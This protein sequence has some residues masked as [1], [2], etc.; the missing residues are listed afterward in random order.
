MSEVLAAS[1]AFKMRD[2]ASYDAVTM[3]FD[4]FSER[5]SIPLATRVVALAGVASGQQVLDVGTGTGIVAIRAAHQVGPTGRV[6]GIDLSEGMLS[7]AA[8][9]A[10]WA[11]L[12]HQLDFRL[13]DAEALDFDDQ[14]FDAVVSLFA[15]LH[16]P[17][18]LVALGEM[19]RVLRPGGRLVVAVG[20][21]PPWLSLT[22]LRHRAHRAPDLLRTLQG[23][24][25]T[26]PHFLNQLVRQALPDGHEPEEAS[27]ARQGLD[28]TRSVLHLVRQAGFTQAQSYWEGH[29]A[30]IETPEEFWDIQRTFSSIARK[31]LS[32][33]PPG[34]LEAIRDEFLATCRQVQ[35]R[36]GRLIYP[37]AAFFVVAQ[38]PGSHHP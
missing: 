17:H 31:R 18:P 34:K 7:A 28:R 29:E 11:G 6:V 19:K 20:S 4:R 16:F 2:A 24:Q 13:M 22:G 23:K 32:S 5:V 27:L 36:G 12:T 38:R 14:T 37:F 21:R 25:L 15:L 30:I 10:A 9:K 35:S 26:A 3:E 1:E 8:T 33:A